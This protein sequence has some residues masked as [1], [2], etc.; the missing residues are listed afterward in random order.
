MLQQE[1]MRVDIEEALLMTL[2][3]RVSDYPVHSAIQLPVGICRLIDT[4]QWKT[5]A[6]SPA[7]KWD[8]DSDIYDLLQT[9]RAHAVTLP[10]C[11]EQT[12]FIADLQ[13]TI[14]CAKRLGNM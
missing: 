12:S 2:L 1:N 9:I 10:G 6:F 11:N 4:G 7:S 14:Y 5:L 8:R 3:E 13:R